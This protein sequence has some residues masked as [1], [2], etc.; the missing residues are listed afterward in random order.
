M[1][2]TL[3]ARALA[4][5]TAFWDNLKQTAKENPGKTCHK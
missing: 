3:S 1:K 4:K 2:K 5:E